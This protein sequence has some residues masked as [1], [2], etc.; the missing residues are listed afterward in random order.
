MRS[1]LVLLVAAAAVCAFAVQDGQKFERKYKAGESDAYAMSMAMETGMG[2]IDVAMTMTQTIK[3]VYD[4]G[5]A[6]IE[7]SIGSM[8]INAMGNEM[9]PPAP[10]A[11]TTRMNNRGVAVQASQGAAGGGRGA[12]GMGML[13]NFSRFG[14]IMTAGEMK[15]GVAVPFE[16]K[17]SG[18]KGT[19]TLE[20]LKDGVAILIS[21]IEVSNPGGGA[22]MVVDT[23]SW[24]D[25]ASSK[26]DKLEGTIKNPPGQ[27]QMP[28]ESMKITMAR[29]K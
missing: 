26:L 4:N 19:V 16:D 28:I 22:P 11:T 10:P 20:S 13:L 23:R 24:I 6:D 29:K 1:K 25:A 8:K 3:K 14:A 9:S 2:S 12:G 17:E 15:V 5:D 21:K 27:D 7:T 18:S